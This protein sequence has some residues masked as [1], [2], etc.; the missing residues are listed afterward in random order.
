MLKIKRRLKRVAPRIV[1]RIEKVPVEPEDK[2]SEVID[3]SKHYLNDVLA[4]ALEISE[5]CKDFHVRKADPSSMRVTEDLNLVYKPDIGDTRKCEMSHFALSQFGTKIGVPANYLE[6][7]VKRGRADIAQYNVNSWLQDYGKPLFIREYR[8]EMG[9]DTV[10]GVL[11]DKYAVCDTPCI[12]EG[13]DKVLDLDN[14][15]VKGHF[16]SPERFHLRL[17]ERNRMEV[18]GEDLFGGISI[19]S[20]AVGRSTLSVRF[21]VYKQVCS[22]GMIVSRGSTQL[23]KQKHIGITAEAFRRGLEEGID[24]FPKIVAKV[25]ESIERTRNSES[26][27]DFNYQD[28]EQLQ[29]L[30]QSI[31]KQTDLSPVQANNVINIM[32]SGRY[33]DN[34]WG[35]INALTEVAQNLT[36]E[37][38]LALEEYAGRLLV[39]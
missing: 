24:S 22:N 7:C 4:S 35:Y 3:V 29:D 14:F 23:F 19:D 38:R 34:R 26:L 33:E 6:K 12:I 32:Q 37:K 13:I 10:R 31:R 9:V 11:S 36:L 27:F 17:A 2:P 18:S 8:N 15:K 28:E 20:S 21:I 1:D 39:A 30:V 16:L 25:A 5:R